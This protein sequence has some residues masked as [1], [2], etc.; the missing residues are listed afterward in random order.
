M[1]ACTYIGDKK[2]KTCSKRCEWY[3]ETAYRCP[4]CGE[5]S[6]IALCFSMM[7]F[8]DF[9]DECLAESDR[10]EAER[11]RADFEHDTRGEWF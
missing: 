11:E 9:G 4:E 5:T 6:D 7:D 2:M 3:W 8:V 1:R 10:A